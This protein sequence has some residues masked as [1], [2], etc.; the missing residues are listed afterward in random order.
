MQDEEAF[1]ARAPHLSY[2]GN[3]QS[4]QHTPVSWA[5]SVQLQQQFSQRLHT[6][7]TED[8][9]LQ[10]TQNHPAQRHPSDT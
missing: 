6:D 2:L 7:Y 5:V 1:P 8:S 4:S 3:V 10:P 9:Q